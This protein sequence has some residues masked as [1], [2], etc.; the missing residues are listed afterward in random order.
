MARRFRFRLLRGTVIEVD[1]ER[2][3]QTQHGPGFEL[4]LTEEEAAHLYRHRGDRD[5]ELVEVI[6][7]EAR[8]ERKLPG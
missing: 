3:R 8:P 2:R 5:Y 7:D 6:D 1:Y 4:E